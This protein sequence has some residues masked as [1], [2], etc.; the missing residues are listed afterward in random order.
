MKE[1]DPK[2]MDPDVIWWASGPPPFDDR[3]IPE[4]TKAI[5]TGRRAV[6]EPAPPS[7]SIEDADHEPGN[8]REL[9]RRLKAEVNILERK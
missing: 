4:N 7:P 9:W 8:L 1:R 6:A 2:R 5:T 3:E